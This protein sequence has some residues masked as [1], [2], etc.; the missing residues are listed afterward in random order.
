MIINIYKKETSNFFEKNGH[1]LKILTIWKKYVSP[2]A[3]EKIM[4]KFWEN[5]NTLRRPYLSDNPP[6]IGA[7]IEIETKII[8]NIGNTVFPHIYWMNIKTKWEKYCAY[9]F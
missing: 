3:C 8:W 4:V 6:M 7:N 9:D 1:C 2:V 5:L